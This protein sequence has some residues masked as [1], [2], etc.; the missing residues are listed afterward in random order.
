MRVINRVY[1]GTKARNTL[2]QPL[3][4]AEDVALTAFSNITRSVRKKR[5]SMPSSQ[6]LNKVQRQRNS[7]DETT[8]L[9]SR[10][11]GSL[12]ANRTRNLGAMTNA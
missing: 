6:L 7:R 8:T 12:D 1:G 9:R 2:E 4:D 10:G 11:D 5:K 3:A